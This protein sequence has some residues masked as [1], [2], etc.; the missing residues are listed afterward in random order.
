[1]F[2]L[3]FG[4][5]IVRLPI[6]ITYFVLAVVGVFVILAFVIKDKPK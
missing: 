4:Y 5:F 2:D 6:W 1:M 3:E